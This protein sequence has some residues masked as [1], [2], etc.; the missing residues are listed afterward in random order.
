[1]Q[2]PVTQPGYHA[3]RTPANKGITLPPEILTPDEVNSLMRACSNRAPTGIRNRALIAVL[4]RSGLRLGEALA[5]RPKDIDLDRGTI[6]VLHGKGDRRRSVGLDPGAIA[7]IERWTQRRKELGVAAQSPVFC[8]LNGNPL[9]PSYVRTLLPRLASKVGIE[10]RV[11]PHG[12]RHTHAFELVMEGV[13][14]PVIQR[15]LGHASLATTDKYLSHIAPR[16]VVEAMAQ[17]NWDMTA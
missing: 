12:L 3:G 1:M 10:K 5:L 6:A 15:Q 9:K 14:I 11:H 13:P 17:R 16:D 8:T 2:S 7:I 4:Y